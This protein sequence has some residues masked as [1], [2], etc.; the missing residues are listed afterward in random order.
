MS[1]RNVKTRASKRETRLIERAEGEAPEKPSSQALLDGFIDHLRI[2]RGYSKHT[3]R[4]YQ[5]DLA[6]FLRWCDR[7]NIDPLDATHRQLRAYLSEMDAARY[8]R[9]TVNRR[10]S[11]LKGFYRW[12]NLA[13]ITDNTPADALSGPKRSKHLPHV[14]RESDMDKLLALRDLPD[15]ADADHEQ[16]PEDIRDQ[17]IFEFL[18]A[19]GARISEAAGLT[20]D[21]IDY[22]SQLVKLFGKRS[23]E[24]IVPVHRICLESLKRYEDHARPEL[25]KGK[26]PTKSFFVSTRGNPMS[27]DAIRVRFKKA[28]REAGLDENLSPH[29][30]RHTFATDLLDGNADLRSVQEMLGHASLSTT[31]IYTHLSTKRIKDAHH[32]AHPRA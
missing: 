19:T 24:R 20:V 10:L 17:A 18:Y 5:T 12:M 4:S 7:H 11:S 9:S 32:Q 27:A 2:E 31:Q 16:T 22:A 25:L 29:D 1:P 14:L 23:K 21:D 26:K 8:A 28:I 30:M 3:V 13:Q 6:A 15:D